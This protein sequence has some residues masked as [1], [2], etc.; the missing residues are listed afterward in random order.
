MKI[1]RRKGREYRLPGVLNDF[2]LEMY[3]HLIDWKWKHLTTEPGIYHH[4]GKDIP[5]D[6]ILPAE[7]KSRLLPIHPSIIDQFLSHQ[8][9][10]PFK[11][12]TFVGHMASSQAA[13]A[14]LF[15]PLLMYPD[16]A[17]RVLQTVKPDLESIA[18]EWFDC[19]YRIE[20]WDEPDNALNDHTPAVGT[21]ADI[22]IAYYNKAGELNLWLIEHK[23]TEAEFT[24][25]GGYRSR[26]RNPASHRCDSIRDILSN[27]ELCYY[28]GVR[29]YRYWEI[30]SANPE[31]FPV[32]KLLEWRACPFQGG[33]NQLWRNTLLA[34][35]VENSTSER[36]PFKQVHFSVVHHPKNKSLNSSMK[37]FRK[38]LGTGDRF[39]SFTSDLLIHAAKQL[40]FEPWHDWLNWFDELYDCSRKHPGELLS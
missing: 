14:N 8:E 34:L 25:C 35:A 21:D 6:A 3:L 7:L 5:Y 16:Q 10:F 24:T 37:A 2:Q 23:L 4:N 39:S 28:A 33:L 12:H 1:Y 18:V 36:W 13:C 27:P 40:G 11:T 15:L 9:K 29:E 30:T 17:A 22:A 31:V 19:G 32:E 20:F 38:L 26:G